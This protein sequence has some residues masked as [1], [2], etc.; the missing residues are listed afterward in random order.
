M[1]NKGVRID[2]RGLDKLQKRVEELSGT[3]HVKLLDLFN[4][5]FMRKNTTFS[6]I[7]EMFEKSGLEIESE[8]DIK[9]NQDVWDE[10]IKRNTNYAGWEAMLNAA[11][12][13]WIK[14]ELGF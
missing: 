3:N 13:E 9:T 10:F 7:E 6:S 2:T 5:G 12:A 11:S 4:V 1:R 8:E 14:K